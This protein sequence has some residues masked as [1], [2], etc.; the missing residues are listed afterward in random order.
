MLHVILLHGLGAH[1]ITLTMFENHVQNLGAK[2]YVCSYLTFFNKIEKI[3]ESVLSFMK[4]NIPT[5]DPVVIIGH[6]LGGI[7][8]RHV[9]SRS[10][11]NIK[12]ILTLGTPHDGAI[13]ANTIFKILP[14]VKMITIVRQL[15][16]NSSHIRT[17]PHIPE[18]IRHVNIIGLKKVDW[19]N[20]INWITGL[21]LR[22]EES[23]DGVVEYTSCIATR[24]DAIHEVDISHIG[25]LFSNTV[26]RIIS[27][28]I[29]RIMKQENLI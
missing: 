9:S 23:H 13:L 27:D 4:I 26:E 3:T 17:C 6:S 8:A 7:I 19:I 15:S 10:T 12:T 22:R 21:L 16:K 20:P 11:H 29:Y 5:N 18:H 2:G 1:G 14:P 24:N 28:E 25:M